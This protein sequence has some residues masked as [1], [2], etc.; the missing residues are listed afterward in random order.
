MIKKLRLRH[1]TILYYAFFFKYIVDY[2]IQKIS[3][4][5]CY[6]YYY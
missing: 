4:G 6:F 5:L 2:L 1:K 3:L